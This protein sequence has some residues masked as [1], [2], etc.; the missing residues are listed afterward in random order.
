MS[1]RLVRI[2]VY[3]ALVGAALSF[4]VTSAL[5]FVCTSD[6]LA[7]AIGIALMLASVVI[8]HK[9]TTVTSARNPSLLLIFRLGAAVCVVGA[10]ISV[11]IRFDRRAQPSNE[12]PYY[13]QAGD[14]SVVASSFSSVENTLLLCIVSSIITFVLVTFGCDAFNRLYATDGVDDDG[15]GAPNKELTVRQVY[16]IV[17]ATLVLGSVEGLLFGG[18]L[19]VE[20][21]A[22]RLG[23]EQVL[24]L[25][26]GLS[27]GAGIGYVNHHAV[28]ESLNIAFEPIS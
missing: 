2:M 26:L 27:T 22:S 3:S 15:E 7:I 18:V 21:H 5:Y 11:V 23:L 6:F 24:G 28:G 16:A 20:D 17:V 4:I 25:M 1:P 9:S 10:V 19:D 13:S 14:S 12:Y 8:Y